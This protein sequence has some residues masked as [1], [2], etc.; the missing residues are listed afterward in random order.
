MRAPIYLNLPMCP[1]LRCSF[2]RPL[3]PSRQASNPQASLRSAGSPLP[4]TA[5]FSMSVKT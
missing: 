5:P 2:E 1:Q 3:G 4:L